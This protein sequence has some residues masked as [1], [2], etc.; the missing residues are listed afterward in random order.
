[1]L[2]AAL[3]TSQW[4]EKLSSETG[5]RGQG[6]N[7]PGCILMELVGQTAQDTP[8][9]GF[10]TPGLRTWEKSFLSSRPSLTEPPGGTALERRGLVPG[11]W[12]VPAR[13][14]GSYIKNSLMSRVMQPHPCLIWRHPD[15]KGPEQ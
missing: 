5:G 4:P 13:T 15:W 10:R 7:N 11:L 1:M 2:R 12:F 3:I 6:V 9:Q 14:R 8:E